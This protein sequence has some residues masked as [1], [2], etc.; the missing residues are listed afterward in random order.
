[1]YATNILLLDDDNHPELIPCHMISRKV[2]NRNESFLHYI[3]YLGAPNL[4]TIAHV[5]KREGK[6]RERKTRDF[7]QVKCIKDEADRLGEG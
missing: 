2:Q 6:L 5:N 3:L 7:N 4:D 1:M